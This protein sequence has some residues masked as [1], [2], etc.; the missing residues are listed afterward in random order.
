M[1]KCAVE[2]AKSTELPQL[3]GPWFLRIGHSE[4]NYLIK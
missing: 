3:F 4:L 2:N 1:M